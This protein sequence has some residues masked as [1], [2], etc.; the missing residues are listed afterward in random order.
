VLIA[1]PM[2]FLFNL[3]WA[4]AEALGHLDMLRS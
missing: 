1:L 2:I 4:C 3:T